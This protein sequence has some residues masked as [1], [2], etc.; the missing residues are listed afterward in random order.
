MYKII[1]MGGDA[2]KADQSYHYIST[3]LEKGS[4][5]EAA[6][7]LYISQS[8]LSQYITRLSQTIGA[9]VFAANARPARLS[10][11][12]KVYMHYEEQMLSVRRQMINKIQEIESLVTGSVTIGASHYRSMTLLVDAIPSFKQQ[13]PGIEILVEEGHTDELVEAASRG[14]TDFSIVMLP[15]NNEILEYVPLFEEEIL[16]ALSPN[17]PLC[18]GIDPKKKQEPPYPELDFSLL[19]DDPFIM[20]KQGQ[21]LR[22]SYNELFQMA[23][24]EPRIVMETDDM[25]TAQSLAAVGVGVAL[26]TD[27]LAEASL[28]S[29]KP[30][31]FSLKQKL[32]TRK[33]VAAYDKRS[34][35]GKAAAAFLDAV[36]AACGK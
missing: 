30:V 21:H 32:A 27:R 9:D 12:G 35:L 14:L 34:P 6:K 15:L 24:I 5:S 10:E 31:Y 16:V 7:A 8:S 28:Y 4:I 29:R 1:L 26:V 22:N 17:H 36:I 23:K 20:I 2:M 3:I 19:K 13:Y 25:P 18:S 33:V 11:A